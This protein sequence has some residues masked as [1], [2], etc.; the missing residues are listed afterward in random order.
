[1]TSLSPSSELGT[2][3]GLDS[4]KTYFLVEYNDYNDTGVSFPAGRDDPTMLSEYQKH[5]IA[6]YCLEDGIIKYYKDGTAV[7]KDGSAIV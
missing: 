6:I 2:S 3:L 1:M 4:S 5:N 7:N